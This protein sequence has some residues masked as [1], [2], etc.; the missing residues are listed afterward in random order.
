MRY[1]ALVFLIAISYMIGNSSY[2]YAQESEPKV[3][4][5]DLQRELDKLMKQNINKPTLGFHQRN[6]PEGKTHKVN[7]SAYTGAA[8]ECGPGPLITS[9]GTVPTVGKT[10]AVSRDLSYLIGKEVWIEGIGKRTVEDSMSERYKNTLDVFMTSKKEA[11]QWGRK[12]N[13]EMVIIE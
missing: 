11:F 3:S 5:S 9:S 12:K 4:I 10:V 7:V 1:K 2:T 13:I 6:K 8:D